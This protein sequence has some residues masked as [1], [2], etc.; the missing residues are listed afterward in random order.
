M[1]RLISAGHPLPFVVRGPGDASEVG[2]PGTL[3]GAFPSSECD[4]PVT[5]VTL[6]PDDIM[7]LFT[8]GVTD[9][10]GRTRAVRGSAPED[11]PRRRPATAGRRD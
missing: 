6:A 8:D 7:F 10:G 3:L 11:D 9:A 4:W 1:A 2:T 5:T